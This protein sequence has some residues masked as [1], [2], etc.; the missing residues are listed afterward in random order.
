MAITIEFYKVSFRGDTEDLPDVTEKFTSLI[1]Q[2]I[3]FQQ[4]YDRDIYDARLIEDECVAGVFRKIRTDEQIQIG[5]PSEEGEYIDFEAGQGKFEN[6]PF[7]YFPQYEVLGYVANPHANHYG[8]FG[9]C[10]TEDF[11]IPVVLLPLVSRSTIEQL[12]SH[13]NVVKLK[14]SIP[15]PR[16]L[17]IQGDNWGNRALQ[18]LSESGA[19]VVDFE[20]KVNL[21]H[22]QHGIID[23]AFSVINS[24]FDMGATKLKATIEN[25][26]GK[27]E[28]IDLIQ[29][30]IV[31]KDPNFNMHRERLHLTDIYPKIIEG[32]LSKLDEIEQIFGTG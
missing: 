31:A 24:A 21:R 16:E 20:V 14:C 32:Y 29:N 2:S 23:N 3:N 8:R 25:I 28:P 12:L 6:N 26:D 27:V 4:E 13:R 7:V 1:G 30:K 5:A 19:D 17:T 22:R 9:K 18:S 15:V 11:D 10:L